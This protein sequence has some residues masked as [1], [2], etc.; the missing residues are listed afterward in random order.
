MTK[1]RLDWAGIVC[2]PGTQIILLSRGVIITGQ[3][4]GIRGTRHLVSSWNGAGGVLGK[5]GSS[6]PFRE[7]ALPLLH[8]PPFNLSI[9]Q[10][11][12]SSSSYLEGVSKF[13]SPG[14]QSKLQLPPPLP[15]PLQFPI[16]QPQFCLVLQRLTNDPLQPACCFLR[17]GVS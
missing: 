2:N 4:R 8:A 14:S 10:E 16:S 5:R 6:D 11:P 1:R 13:T 3:G 7:Q 9:S 12:S 17:P 15:A